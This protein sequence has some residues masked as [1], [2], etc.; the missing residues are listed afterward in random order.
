MSSARAAS[1][2]WQGAGGRTRRWHGPRQSGQGAAKGPTPGLQTPTEVGRSPF[3]DPAPCLGGGMGS[4]PSCLA[5]AAVSVRGEGMATPGTRGRSRC[6]SQEDREGQP[7]SAR[8]PSPAS[9]HWVR[10]IA[11][12]LSLP[13]CP[14]PARVRVRGVARRRGNHLAA[15]RRAQLA[16]WLP[17]PLNLHSCR[18][19]GLELSARCSTVAGG[20]GVRRTVIECVLGRLKDLSLRR[21]TAG[22]GGGAV[23]WFGDVG[24]SRDGRE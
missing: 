22:A 1:Q 18:P 7:R 5:E 10:G 23:R 12:Q 15:C 8:L 17:S 16:A 21:S 4:G 20:A 13:S 6:L 11:G 24:P 19:S 14:L 9:R 2:N 3:P